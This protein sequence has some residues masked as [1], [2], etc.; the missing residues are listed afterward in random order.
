MESS[1]MDPKLPQVQ[2]KKKVSSASKQ[3]HGQTLSLFDHLF[4]FLETNTHFVF[5]CC[6][7]FVVL[8]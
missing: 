7:L 6:F 3:N 4:L 2:R 1:S 5:P 8:S